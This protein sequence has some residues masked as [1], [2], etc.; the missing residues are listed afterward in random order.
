MQERA[1]LYAGSFSRFGQTTIRV[2][3]AR[4]TEAAPRAAPRLPRGKA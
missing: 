1:N 4:Q 2:H 3:G